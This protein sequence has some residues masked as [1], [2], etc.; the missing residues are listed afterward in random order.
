MSSS[1]HLERRYR[2]LLAFYPAAF[3]DEQE[4]EILTLSR[5]GCT[6]SPPEVS[7]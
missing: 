6:N 3:R 1:P 4:E 2:R 5:C 7:T